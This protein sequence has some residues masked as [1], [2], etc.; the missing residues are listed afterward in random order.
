MASIDQHFYDTVEAFSNAIGGVFSGSQDGVGEK[1]CAILLA[2]CGVPKEQADKLDLT[3]PIKLSE[4]KIPESGFYS[5]NISKEDLIVPR[6]DSSTFLDTLFNITNKETSSPSRN[7]IYHN[8][9]GGTDKF[10][11]KIP[12]LLN[13][14]RKFKD[15]DKETQKDVLEKLDGM[16]QQASK[17]DNGSQKWLRAAYILSVHMG[18]PGMK[19]IQDFHTEGKGFNASE[20]NDGAA[21]LFSSTS[22]LP[23]TNQGAM[24]KAVF[25]SLAKA[26]GE[27]EATNVNDQP[28]PQPDP[29]PVP[30]PPVPNNQ[31]ISTYYQFL[32]VGTEV[33]QVVEPDHSND[34]YPTIDDNVRT[35]VNNHEEDYRDIHPDV[36]HDINRQDHPVSK[37]TPDAE[38]N[39]QEH[40]MRFDNAENI[41]AEIE[42]DS[43]DIQIKTIGTNTNNGRDE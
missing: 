1:T 5:N 23:R 4:L 20:A 18:L 16:M 41:T 38:E 7:N 11:D 35:E 2:F 31:D 43:N 17:E 19:S 12:G 6:T 34:L 3:D 27:L 25:D 28:V 22:V 33:Q 30:V 8:V 32:K 13:G 39:K 42:G 10:G 24:R 29:Q 14:L 21:L 37:I 40:K 26:K 9:Y 15:M 36:Y